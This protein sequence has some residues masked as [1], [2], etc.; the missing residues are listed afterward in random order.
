M[1]R[2]A[3]WSAVMNADI[4][5]ARNSQTGRGATQCGICTPNTAVA[6]AAVSS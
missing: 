1:A 6:G 5:S 2:T 3:D 4:M